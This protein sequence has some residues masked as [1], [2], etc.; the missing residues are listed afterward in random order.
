MFTAK[1]QVIDTLGSLGTLSPAEKQPSET[2]PW[3]SAVGHASTGKSGRVIERL[4]AEIDKLNRDK[5]VVKAQIEDAEKAKEASQTQISYLQDRN[6]NLEQSH[7][8]DLRSMKRKD[9]KIEELRAELQKEKLRTTNAQ[10]TATAAVR[11]E[12]L[13]QDAARRANM[14]ASQREQE[15]EA[16]KGVRERERKQCQSQVDKLGHDFSGLLRER[17]DDEQKVGRLSIVVE[18]QKHIINQ[19]QEDNRKTDKNYK[20]YCKHVDFL[21]ANLRA[22]FGAND[23]DISDTVEETRRVLGQMKWVMNVQRDVQ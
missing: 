1:H 21:L 19:L 6:S 17:K 13:A 8:A 15:Y 18:Q 2:L 3:S 10:D 12:E 9:R 4:Q 23:Q 20:E 14:L 22:T 16:I 5:H 7:E 11:S